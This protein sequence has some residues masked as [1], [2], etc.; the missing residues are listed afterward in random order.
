MEI[1]QIESVAASALTTVVVAQ[2]LLS[3]VSRNS[4]VTLTFRNDGYGAAVTTAVSGGS[5]AVSTIAD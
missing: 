2:R 1:D 3:P 5:V 4:T